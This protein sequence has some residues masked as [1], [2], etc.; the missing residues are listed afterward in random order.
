MFELQGSLSLDQ[1]SVGL[2]EA[3]LLV[4]WK[5]EPLLLASNLEQKD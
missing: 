4:L 3:G 5:G 2:G 1:D